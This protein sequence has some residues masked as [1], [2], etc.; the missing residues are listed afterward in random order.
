MYTST[1]PNF[2]CPHPG[3]NATFTSDSGY[4]RHL[5]RHAGLHQ[6][7]C[8]Y[9]NKGLSST[10]D[11]KKHLRSTHTKLFGFH[12]INCSQEFVSVHHLKQHLD[13]MEC[14]FQKIWKLWLI[15]G[16]IVSSVHLYSY[17]IWLFVCKFQDKSNVYF[18]LRIVL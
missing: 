1:M 16:I 13:S 9:C 6:Y 18:K 3:C 11:V 5:N 4:K 2:H 10:K 7:N 8:P 15:F 17:H 12:C 14:G